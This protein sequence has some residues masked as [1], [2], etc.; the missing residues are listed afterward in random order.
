MSSTK[1][2]FRKAQHED[3]P[4]LL[5]LRQLSMNE[6]LA[7]AGIVMNVQQ[8]LARINEFFDDSNIICR[9]KVPIGLLKF[10]VIVD[11]IH[12][13]QFQ[14]LP[15]HHGYGIGGKVLTILQRKAQERNLPITLNVLLKNPALKLYQRHDFVI[16]NENDL[17]YQMRWQ[18]S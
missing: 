8:H 9:N 14:L 18:C 12:I 6:H 13:R 5:N 17:E 2:T 16:E 10:A 15:D 3:I 11:R 1:I 7:N 4:F